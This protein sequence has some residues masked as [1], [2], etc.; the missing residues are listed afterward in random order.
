MNV[1]IID[2]EKAVKNIET[3]KGSKYNPYDKEE[4]DEFGNVGY[5]SLSWSI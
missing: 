4:V 5:L 1:N 2:S 3:K